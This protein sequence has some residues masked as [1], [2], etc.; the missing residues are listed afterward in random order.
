MHPDQHPN[1]SAEEIQAQLTLW[2]HPRPWRRA[3]DQNLPDFPLLNAR[4][5]RAWR[6]WKRLCLRAF[7]RLYAPAYATTLG[8]TQL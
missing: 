4:M 7:V 2:L 3:R 6:L 1:D 5:E 8:W